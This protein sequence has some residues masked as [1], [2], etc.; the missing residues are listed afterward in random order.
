MAARRAPPSKA[1]EIINP[2]ISAAAAARTARRPPV[3]RDDDPWSQAKQNDIPAAVLKAARASGQL[4]LSN[5]GLTEVPSKVW[6]INLDAG[7]GQEVSMNSDGDRWWDQVDLTKLILASNKLTRIDAGITQLPM[8]SV[9]D[10]HDNQLDALPDEIGALVSMRSL[11]LGNN[12]LASLPYTL[13][14]LSAL[15]I[16]LAENNN[17]AVL[18]V[19]CWVLSSSILTEHSKG[20]GCWPAWRS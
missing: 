3:A 2:P 14:Q 19:C 7:V 20:L 18:P 4:N 13:G 15:T 1:A 10:V 17:I 8:L 11:N 5:K 6:R 9:L 12:R 16:L